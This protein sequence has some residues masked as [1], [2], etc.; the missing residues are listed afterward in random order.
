MAPRNFS[1]ARLI[2]KIKHYC[3]YRERS[4]AEVKN[5]LY[6]FGLHRKDVDEIIVDLTG[7]SYVNEERFAVNFAGGKFRIKH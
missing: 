6:S 4:R 7:E 1:P 3:G 5:K 2:S